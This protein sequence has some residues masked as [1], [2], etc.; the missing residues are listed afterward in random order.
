MKSS[1]CPLSDRKKSI[2]NERDLIS[3]IFKRREKMIRLEWVFLMQ[4]FMGIVM[5]IFLQKLV[6]MKRQIDEVSKEILQY[7][8]YVTED[9]EQEFQKEER[10]QESKKV[11]KKDKEYE[12][13]SLIQ[14]VLGEYF[15]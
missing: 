3:L 15:Q 1:P 10:A 9:V 11:S 7:I 5:I 13:N 14:A 8:S 6:Q 2:Y 12:Q 4:V